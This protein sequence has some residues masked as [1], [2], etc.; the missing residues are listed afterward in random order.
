M[1][2]SIIGVI[3]FMCNNIAALTSHGNFSLT[4]NHYA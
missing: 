4:L 3:N 2:L 1:S